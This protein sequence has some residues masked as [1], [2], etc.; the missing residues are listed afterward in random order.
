MKSI[1]AGTLAV[2][3][4]LVLSLLV[5]LGAFKSVTIARETAGPFK[6]VYKQHVG[7]YHKIVP[8][9]EEVET[10][11]AKNNEPCEF[12]FGEYLDDPKLID[13]DRLKS[14]AGCIVTRDWSAGLPE[15]FSYREIPTRD[16]VIADFD[17][18]PSIG[19]YKAYPKATEFISAQGL[20]MMG[21][22]TEVYKKL[23][24]GGVHTRYYFPVAPKP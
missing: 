8:T 3:A 15:G 5:Y 11:A 10:W 6:Q 18:A 20:E 4:A 7:A 13:E 14:N 1:I 24:N 16:Y 9:L 2:I 22:V 19:P 12:S 23:P 17:G 21:A